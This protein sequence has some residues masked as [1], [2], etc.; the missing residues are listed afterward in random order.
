MLE[1]NSKGILGGIFK[2]KCNLAM[3]ECLKLKDYV[4]KNSDLTKD[5]YKYNLLIEDK[6]GRNIEKK[7]FLFKGSHVDGRLKEL[8]KF[9]FENNSVKCISENI[10]LNILAIDTFSKNVFVYDVKED[11]SYVYGKL[12]KKIK[13]KKDSAITFMVTRNDVKVHKKNI[14]TKLNFNDVESLINKYGY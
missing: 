3:K 4:K 7:Y 12:I 10:K 8:K 14:N 11:D 1:E 9:A 5:D 2:L 6:K 13:D